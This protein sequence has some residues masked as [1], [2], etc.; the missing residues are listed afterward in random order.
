MTTSATQTVGMFSCNSVSP[1]PPTS[2][3]DIENLAS[4]YPGTW[5][6]DKGK[7]LVTLFKGGF[8]FVLINTFLKK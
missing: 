3:G 7:I 8:F 5:P 4:M 6:L 2:S 1:P